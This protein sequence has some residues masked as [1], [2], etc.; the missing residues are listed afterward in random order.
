MSDMLPLRRQPLHAAAPPP[1]TNKREACAKIFV[2]F[3]IVDTRGCW[4]GRRDST[5]ESDMLL[6]FPRPT[7]HRFQ[8]LEG[9]SLFKAYSEETA[10]RA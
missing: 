3:P 7:S 9:Q 10:V 1:H 6:C 8:S 2:T 4:V 5:C